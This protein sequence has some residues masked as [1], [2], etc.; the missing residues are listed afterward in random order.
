MEAHD[1]STAQAQEIAE[2]LAASVYTR[3]SV[4]DNGV[5]MDATTR[6]RAFDPFFTTRTVGDGTGLGLSV[7]QGI[8]LAHYGAI[9]VESS[10]GKGSAFHV[11]LPASAAQVTSAT[12]AESAPS[13]RKSTV[14]SKVPHVAY[15]D[16]EAQQVRAM[17]LLFERDGYRASGFPD[18]ESALN[19]FRARPDEFDLLVTDFNMPGSSGV[20]L[21]REVSAIRPSLPVIIVSGYITEE[22]RTEAARAGVRHVLYKSMLKELRQTVRS[23]VQPDGDLKPAVG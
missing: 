9:V 11:Y 12:P 4:I 6:A 17:T 21:V 15:V 14:S 19:V 20:D 5:G 8:V 10:P 1:L 7:V 3:L 2:D 18:G 23:L 13:V 22:L 16:D